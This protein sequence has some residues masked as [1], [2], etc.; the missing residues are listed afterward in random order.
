MLSALNQR[1]PGTL[2]EYRTQHKMFPCKQ[3]GINLPADG[4]M[5]LIQAAASWTHPHGKAVYE[6]PEIAAIFTP[7]TTTDIPVPRWRILFLPEHR[8]LA[9]L[10]WSPAIPGE[11]G[12]HPFDG[13]VGNRFIPETVYGRRSRTSAPNGFVYGNNSLTVSFLYNH[14]NRSR[15]A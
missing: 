5:G 6:V 7:P 9:A 13:F 2:A 8:R 14:R 3:T 10:V 12:D 11:G 15:T 4:T 1:R